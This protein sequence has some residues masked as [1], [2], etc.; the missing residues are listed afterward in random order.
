MN[1][2]NDDNGP[3]CERFG[4]LDV[5]IQVALGEI[6][7][8]LRQRASFR[9]PWARNVFEKLSQ[10]LVHQCGRT[11]IMSRRPAPLVGSQLDILM[12]DGIGFSGVIYAKTGTP[13]K[14]EEKQSE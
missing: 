9:K 11:Y 2:G 6:L 8:P 12:K 5:S 7:R 14:N 4:S 10:R 13:P 1:F 3:F